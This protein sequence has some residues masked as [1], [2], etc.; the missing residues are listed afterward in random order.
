MSEHAKH[1]QPVQS[2]WLILTEVC[3]ITGYWKVNVIA[4]ADVLRVEWFTDCTGNAYLRDGSAR[5][6]AFATICKSN[7]PYFSIEE[8]IK[9]AKR[10]ERQKERVAKP[11]KASINRKAAKDG[12]ALPE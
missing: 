4:W 8:C 11:L 6:F 5:Q 9:V 2:L 1:Q 3:D 12:E 7:D 10:R